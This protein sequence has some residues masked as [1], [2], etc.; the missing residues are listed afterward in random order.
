MTKEQ[1]VEAL[2]QIQEGVPARFALHPEKYAILGGRVNDPGFY[3]TKDCER[4]SKEDQEKYLPNAIIYVN[5]SKQF[6]DY[7][8]IV[9][10]NN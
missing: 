5:I 3:Y 2:K 8:P 9:D 7:I 6:P 1:K 4:I 10:D